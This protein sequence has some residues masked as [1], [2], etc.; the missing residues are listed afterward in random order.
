[1]AKVLANGLISG[2]IGDIVYYPF[3]GKQCARRYVRPN[4]PKTDEQL[5]SRAILKEWMAF[6]NSYRW[7]FVR[8]YPAKRP[9]LFDQD[10]AAQHHLQVAFEAVIAEA[11]AVVAPVVEA[12]VAGTNVAE[13]KKKAVC[14]LIPEKVKFSR[15][16]IAPPEINSCVR[17]GLEIELT[18][19]TS[20]GDVPNLYT[21][22]LCVAAY[23]PGKKPFM[24]LNAGT[25]KQGQ[26]KITLP[27]YK[28]EPVHLWAFFW[29]NEISS[30][31]PRDKASESVYLVI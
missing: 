6:L 30:R 24:H 12:A 20:L 19:N 14:S 15:G 10:E 17:S 26:A 21:D 3:R 1:M 9:V 16:R 11:P 29:N 28:N 2:R 27:D 4:D 22:M 13:V 23:V 5:K 7:V 31:K 18:W 25:R 8:G